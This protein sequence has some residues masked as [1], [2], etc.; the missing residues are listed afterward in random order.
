MSRNKKKL[1]S[2]QK[3]ERAIASLYVAQGVAER[4]N[5]ALIEFYRAMVAAGPPQE[6]SI[7]MAKH[8]EDNPSEQ[9]DWLIELLHKR[10]IE[11]DRKLQKEFEKNEQSLFSTAQNYRSRSRYNRNSFDRE[12]NDYLTEEI[13]DAY[14]WINKRWINDGEVK[15]TPGELAIC[16]ALRVNPLDHTTWLIHTGGCQGVGVNCDE[17]IIEYEIEKAREAIE[18][19]EERAAQSAE[20]K[21]ALAR[22]EFAVGKFVL[23]WGK[24]IGRIVKHN[25]VSAKVEIT[26]GAY[27]DYQIDSKSVKP[28]FM[29]PWTKPFDNKVGDIVTIRCRDGRVREAT[30]IEIDEPFFRARYTLKNKENREQIFG[31]NNI[32]DAEEESAKKAAAEEK[33]EREAKE[34]ERIREE[35]IRLNRQRKQDEIDRRAH[36]EDERERRRTARNN[37]RA[38]APATT[39]QSS[40]Q[41]DTNKQP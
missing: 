24:R 37:R 3:E 22:P 27:N 13:H 17:G 31:F 1:S 39:I 33:R 30:I 26:G 4:F 12:E 25:R 40:S 28:F 34:N 6:V 20:N 19:K 18:R 21:A 10:L 23:C 7:E 16:K 5:L 41:K 38:T 2:A 14:F 29:K 36:E 11:K 35:Q 32:F 8:W 9:P 15:T